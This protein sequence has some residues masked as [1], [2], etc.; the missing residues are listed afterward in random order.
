MWVGTRGLGALSYAPAHSLETPQ[1]LDLDAVEKEVTRVLENADRVD[2]DSLIAVGGSPQGARPKALVHLSQNGK[3]VLL[4][5]AEAPPGFAPYLVKFRAKADPAHSANLELAYAQMAKAAGI[6]IPDTRL[7]DGHFAVRRFDRLDNGRRR[8]LH[9][10]SGLLHASHQVPSLTYADLLKVTLQLTRNDACVAEMFR[11]A[12]FNV[13]ARNRDDHAKNFSF[14]MNEKGEWTISP[15]YDLTYAEGMGGEH[16]ML[17]GR[18]GKNPWDAD[19]LNL[20]TQIGLK[21]PK[22]ILDE[23]KDAVAQFDTFADHAGV[24]KKVRAELNALLKRTLK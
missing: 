23:V 3:E 11:R 8:H 22:A 15:A 4:N 14:L 9:T 7:L 17:I 6:D 10:L 18:E 19:L 1:T 13:Y 12:C 20:A 5:T 2:L 16:M 21:H 24:P